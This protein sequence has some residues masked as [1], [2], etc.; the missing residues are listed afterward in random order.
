ML[1]TLPFLA[2]LLLAGCGDAPPRVEDAATTGHAAPPAAAASATGDPAELQGRVAAHWFGRQWPKN[3]LAGFRRADVDADF[4]QLRDDGFDTVVLL[5]AWGDFQPV[6]EPCCSWDE[7]AFERLGFLLDRADAA[8]LKVMLRIG[9]GWSFHPGFGDVGERQQLLLNRRDHRAAYQRFVERIGRE[10]DGHDGVV[11]AF[12]SWE[13]Q[14]LRRV[15]ESAREDWNAFVATLPPGTVQGD[16]L[17]DLQRDSALFHRYWDWLVR[18]TLFL[19]AVGVLPNLSYEARVDRE[20]VWGEDADGNR[21]VVEW[22][23]HDGMMQMPE[24]H[25]LT[26]YWAPFWG[27]L[28]QGEQLPASRAQELFAALLAEAGAKSGRGLFIDQFNFVDNTPGHETN[29]VLRPEEIPAFLHRAV[30]T[31]RNGGVV[32]YGLWTARDYTENP[33]HN[34]AFGYGLEGWTL[35]RVDGARAEAALDALPEGDFRLRLRPGDVLS[36][37]VPRRHGRLPRHGDPLPDQACVQAVVHTPGTLVL[38]AGGAPARLAFDG[39][40]LQ[41]RCAML[42]PRPGDDGLPVTLALDGGELS[43]HDVQVFDHVQYGGVRDVVGDAGPLLAPVRRM[44]A[45]F[46]AEALPARCA[47]SEVQ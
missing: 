46:R 42:D 34:P 3:W 30:C 12:M 4:R 19:P 38:T 22:L 15:D 9:Y 6:A 8:G 23:A 18:E 17:P 31:M 39:T 44:N 21:T 24:G 35:E 32:G 2:A 5:V 37:R 13:D 36:Q 10:I 20:P 28:N 45:D 25:V 7:R 47:A 26:I 40:G 1:R 29:A 43:L 33:L 11:M 41:R 27:A 14:W 16:A